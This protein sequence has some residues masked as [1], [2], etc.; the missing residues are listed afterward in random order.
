MDIVWYGL[1]CFRIRE[2]NV[3]VVCD[4]FDKSVGGLMPKVRADIVTISH[5][6]PG[7][8]S[9]DRVSGEPH[10]IKGPGEYEI[11]NVFVMG[12]PSR[13][14]RESASSAERNVA[15]FMDVAGITICHLGDMGEIPKK[16]QLD[17]LKVGEI[18]IL[19]VPIG[20]RETL[21]PTLA[22]EIVGMLEPKLL[23]PMHYR[24]NGL[25]AK[26][27]QELEPVDTFIRELGV[28]MPEPETTLKISKS[29]LPE[30]TQVV[31]LNATQ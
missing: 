7:H 6:K 9:L 25:S 14:Q 3:T 15:Y 17:E 5:E 23:I 22:V 12:M 13:H 10:I 2:G 8:G 26:W 27:I 16:S 29:N 1:S 4:P 18:D 30:E 31:L 21:D 28:S 24:Q 11:Q 19:M 20:G